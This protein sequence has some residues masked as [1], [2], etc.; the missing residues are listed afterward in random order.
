MA[1]ICPQTEEKTLYINCLE[2]EDKIRCK[3]EA[4]KINSPNRNK[5]ASKQDNSNKK[6]QRYGK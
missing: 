2:C 4:D 3:V 6:E 1:K 5:S